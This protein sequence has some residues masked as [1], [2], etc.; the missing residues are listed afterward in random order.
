MWEKASSFVQKRRKSNLTLLQIIP[1]FEKVLFSFSNFCFQTKL[2][3]CLYLH[4]FKNILVMKPIKTLNLWSLGMP[5]NEKLQSH[6]T[7]FIELLL[8]FTGCLFGR[9]E[10]KLLCEAGPHPLIPLCFFT[11]RSILFSPNQTDPSMCFWDEFGFWGSSIPQDA[12]FYSPDTISN[13]Y[14]L[15]KIQG[16]SA[17]P[18]FFVSF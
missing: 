12:P 15:W 5:V 3:W 17:F 7:W 8:Q 9:D 16:I 10:V 6:T 14:I 13:S 1:R 2:L 4:S 18:N 11:S